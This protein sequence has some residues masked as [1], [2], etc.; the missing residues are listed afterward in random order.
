M[1]VHK[2]AADRTH[3]RGI[4]H[5]QYFST[6]AG[7]AEVSA[8]INLTVAGT[9]VP[10]P[11]DSKIAI[12]SGTKCGATADFRGVETY[13]APKPDIEAPIVDFTA[14]I[15][16]VSIVGG[17]VAAVGISTQQAIVLKFNEAVQT[18]PYSSC[19]G[20]ISFCPTAS[21]TC[22]GGIYRPCTNLTA[23]KDKV[24]ISPHTL[25]LGDATEYY[26]RVDTGAIQDLAGNDMLVINSLTEY[27][28]TT[29]GDATGP[30][31]IGHFP[32]K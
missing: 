6:L 26:L 19:R 4:F 20:Q 12:T 9:R 16:P 25:S 32:S 15:P 1:T 22:S 23:D 29:D 5:N 27:L 24:L 7:T 17:S 21:P 31:V 11:S 30:E 10:V 13:V 8:P 2:I 18:G 14:S 28:L 3:P